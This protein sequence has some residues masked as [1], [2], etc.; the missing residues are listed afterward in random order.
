MVFDVRDGRKE[1]NRQAYLL[2]IAILGF[3]A[4]VTYF[5]F[6]N[7]AVAKKSKLTSSSLKYPSPTN[8]AL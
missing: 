1:Q 4:V 7:P 6:Y 2:T 8:C 5:Q 3:S